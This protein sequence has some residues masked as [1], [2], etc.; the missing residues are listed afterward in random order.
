MEH[1]TKEKF[2][3]KYEHFDHDIFGTNYYSSLFSILGFD[4]QNSGTNR[5]RIWFQLFSVTKN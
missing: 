1:T 5:W 2:A 4:Y 3:T